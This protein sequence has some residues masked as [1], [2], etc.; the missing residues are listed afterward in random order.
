MPARR[1]GGGGRAQ[2]PGAFPFEVLGEDLVLPPQLVEDLGRQVQ[3]ERVL[4]GDDVEA[5]RVAAHEGRRATG[6][7]LRAAEDEPALRVMRLDRTGP[8][9]HQ[10]VAVPADRH[11]V[12]AAPVVADRQPAGQVMPHPM[13]QRVEG[14]VQ[15][16]EVDDLRQLGL[17]HAPW[18]QARAA[19]GQAW[20]VRGPRTRLSPECSGWSS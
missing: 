17:G 8:D 11:Q 9:D 15:R 12:A 10:L 1:D 4:D 14:G 6:R 5:G 18:W 20:S 19:R 16:Q 2:E 3:G 13:G 7:A